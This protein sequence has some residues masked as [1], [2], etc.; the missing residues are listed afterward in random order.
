MIAATLLLIII[1]LL[2]LRY[3]LKFKSKPSSRSHRDR[4][5]DRTASARRSTPTHT[6]LDPDMPYA[7]IAPPS[8]A[9][10]LLADRRIQERSATEDEDAI[11]ITSDT[12]SNHVD[13]DNEQA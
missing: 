6:Q 13:H 5:N 2:I 10:T 1:L 11:L 4:G 12:T 3:L 8:Y 7:T 9:D